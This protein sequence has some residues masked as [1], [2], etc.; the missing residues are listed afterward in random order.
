[1]TADGLVEVVNARGRSELWTSPS[2]YCMICMIL[3]VRPSRIASCACSLLIGAWLTCVSSA[4][5]SGFGQNAFGFYEFCWF[6]RWKN[7]QSFAGRFVHLCTPQFLGATPW[8]PEAC[9]VPTMGWTRVPTESSP[10]LAKLQGWRQEHR[11]SF[12]LVQWRIG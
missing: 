3:N 7:D 12:K 10:R 11:G 6:V 8:E 5:W 1:M 2:M 9:M 4:D